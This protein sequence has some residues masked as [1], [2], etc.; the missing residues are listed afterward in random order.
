M[1]CFSGI[2]DPGCFG[3]TESGLQQLDRDPGGRPAQDAKLHFFRCVLCVRAS[4]PHPLLLY[5]DQH[6][7]LRPV[8]QAP[9]PR[10]PA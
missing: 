8:R 5:T 2:Q 6:L 4:Q 1:L 10:V 9:H 3:E 7:Q